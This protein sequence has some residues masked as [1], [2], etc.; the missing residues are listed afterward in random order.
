MHNCVSVEHAGQSESWRC[1]LRYDWLLATQPNVSR[2][3]PSLA[4]QHCV[5]WEALEVSE[6]FRDSESPRVG[7]FEDG[8][9]A[10]SACF[11]RE[12]QLRM[13]P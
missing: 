5:E 6:V 8:E 11:F 1:G 4:L 12:S 2:L 9:A 7:A 3:A 13:K 10:G